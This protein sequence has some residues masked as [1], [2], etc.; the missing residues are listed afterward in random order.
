MFYGVQ[1][2]KRYAFAVDN[3]EAYMYLMDTGGVGIELAK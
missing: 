1:D 3:A 2:T